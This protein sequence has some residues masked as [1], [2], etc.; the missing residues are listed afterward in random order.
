MLCRRTKRNDYGN[1]ETRYYPNSARSGLMIQSARNK[2]TISILDKLKKQGAP[3]PSGVSAMGEYTEGEPEE[4]DASG[5][6]DA[7]SDVTSKLRR[8]KK[9][10]EEPESAP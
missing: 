6:V 9:L 4:A 7:T 5:T 1:N 2:L 3:S 10:A 8:K